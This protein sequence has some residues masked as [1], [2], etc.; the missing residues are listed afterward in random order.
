MTIVIDAS[1][2]LAW[3]FEDESTRETE[4][5]LDRVSDTGAVVPAHWR[6][7]LAN[8]LQ[9]A[10]RRQRIDTVYRD[11]SLA[12]LAV[13]PIT[14]DGDTNSYAWSTTLRLAERFSLTLYDAA[15]LELARRR[16]L[17]LATLD[18][19]LRGAARMLDIGVLGTG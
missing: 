19:D 4:E 7:E 2:A 3:Y 17:P 15:Y 5:L 16:S 11:D 9:M 10:I 8:A 1:L 6:L 14:I 13:M 18:R 12:E